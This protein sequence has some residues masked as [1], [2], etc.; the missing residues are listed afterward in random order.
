MP[1]TFLLSV[2]VVLSL[3]GCAA[4]A[5]LSVPPAAPTGQDRRLTPGLLEQAVV[6]SQHLGQLHAEVRYLEDALLRAEQ[7][8]LNA[9]RSP[10]AT[11]VD[12]MAYQRCQ[13]KDQLYE[14]L[15][16]DAAAARDR[17]LRAMSGRGGVSQ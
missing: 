15:K 9:C 4:P 1:H 17:Y 2:V 10:E 6:R 11:Q 14:Q 7:K 5:Y 16:A 13:L 3:L 12:S 8:R